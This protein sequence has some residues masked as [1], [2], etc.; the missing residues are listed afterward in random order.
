MASCT[1]VL[2]QEGSSGVSGS[3]KITQAS[4]SSSTVIEGQISGLT[5]GQKHGISVCTYGDLSQ[6]SAS[7]GTSF[8]PFGMSSHNVIHVFV[9]EAFR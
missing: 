5:P 7:C 1:C 6:G 4:D 9:F 2:Q 8:N 3:L